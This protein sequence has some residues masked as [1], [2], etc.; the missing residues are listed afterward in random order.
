[1][2]CHLRDPASAKPIVARLLHLR[3]RRAPTERSSASLADLAVEEAAIEEQFGRIDIL[4]DAR[5]A[6][7][8]ACALF[9]IFAIAINY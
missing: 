1:M 8:P 3:I 5:R 2:L 6:S 7:R 9:D 4:F